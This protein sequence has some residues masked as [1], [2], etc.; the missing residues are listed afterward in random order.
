LNDITSPQALSATTATM[1]ATM[2]QVHA[3]ATAAT[4]VK[5][6]KLDKCFLH[7]TKTGAYN[8]TIKIESLLLHA[9]ISSAITMALNTQNLLLPLSETTQQLRWQHMP[10]THFS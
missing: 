9:Q 10:F 8:A 2:T 7:P 3:I 4:K 6:F 1:T 5:L